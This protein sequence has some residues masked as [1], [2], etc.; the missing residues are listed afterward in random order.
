MKSTINA[1][2]EVKVEHPVADYTKYELKQPHIE[3][4]ELP[5]VLEIFG[6]AADLKTQDLISSLS[7]T[8]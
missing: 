5:H 1:S 8:G 7:S 6:F 2:G 3:D 4:H